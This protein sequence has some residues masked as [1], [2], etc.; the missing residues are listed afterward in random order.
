M[1]PSLRPARRSRRGALAAGLAASAVAA[2]CSAVEGPLPPETAGETP[3]EAVTT[4][5]PDASTASSLPERGAGDAAL[6][7]PEGAGADAA[8]GSPATCGLQACAPGAP[9]PDLIIDVDALR[10]SVVVTSREFAPTDCAVVEGC[11]D[12]P[13]NRRLLRFTTATA[14]VGTADLVVGDPATGECFQWS[15]CH[16]HY[17]FLGFSDYTLYANDGN[18]VAAR[19]HKQSFCL[20]DTQAY[21]PK[22]GAA[23]AQPFDCNEQGIHVGWEDVYSSDIDCQWVD[24]TGVPAGDYL[25]QVSIN[26]AGYLPESDTSNDTAL[27]AVTIPPGSDD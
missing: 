13:G 11:I 21:P 16:M 19:G 24:V 23:P 6:A 7:P 20:E 25:L 2:A 3:G 9:C 27:V 26:T 15:P 10:A 5:A 18:T 8:P 17:H 12:S 14:N 22:P 4:T 1:K